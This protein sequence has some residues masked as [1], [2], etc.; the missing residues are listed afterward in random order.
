MQKVENTHSH[1]LEHTYPLVFHLAQ[2]H[3][4]TALKIA[5]LG[6]C[7]IN[8]GMQNFL[9]AV[10]V[11]SLLH[12]EERAGNSIEKIEAK[13]KQFKA[14]Q[15]EIKKSKKALIEGRKGLCSS[16][17]YEKYSIKKFQEET[18]VA[19]F[20]RVYGIP[21]TPVTTHSPNGLITKPSSP[22]AI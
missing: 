13:I 9:L 12:S 8:G 10:C 2:E 17:K 19:L 22:R 11:F 4:E 16:F 14:I 3:R 6:A 7:V 1:S 20:S 15:T 18:V 5:I 21:V